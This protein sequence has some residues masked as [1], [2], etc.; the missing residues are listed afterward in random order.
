M[1]DRPPRIVGENALRPCWGEHAPQRGTIA[2]LP[3]AA[4][5]GMISMYIQLA[6][7]VGLP[8]IAVLFGCAPV[9]P[10]FQLKLDKPEEVA[11]LLSS[12]ATVIRP[13]IRHQ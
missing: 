12:P 6:R 4:G 1:M 3:W 7:L 2:Q 13:P 8:L 9:S 11:C 5:G 10:A